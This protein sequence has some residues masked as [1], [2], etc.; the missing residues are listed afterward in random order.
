MTTT[1]KKI[2]Q[3]VTIVDKKTVIINMGSEDGIKENDAF[4]ILKKHPYILK[5]PTTGEVLGEF[6]QKKQRVYVKQLADKYCICISTYKQQIVVHDFLESIIPG[7]VTTDEKTIG[8][9]MNVDEKELN[10]IVSEFDYSTIHVGDKVQ[11]VD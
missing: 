3:I 6:K 8:Q 10:D 7:V 5:D 2:P 4:D 1:V 11:K 9:D